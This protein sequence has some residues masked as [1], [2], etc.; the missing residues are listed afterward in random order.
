MRSE[1]F[2]CPQKEPEGK[3]LYCIMKARVKSNCNSNCS[4]NGISN[5]KLRHAIV[6]S[7]LCQVG[8]IVMI[9]SKNSKS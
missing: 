9:L 3:N 2:V 8:K 5:M 7:L 1:V 6:K 4:Q